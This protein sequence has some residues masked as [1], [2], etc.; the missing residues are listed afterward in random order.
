MKSSTA[1]KHNPWDIDGHPFMWQHCWCNCTGYQSVSRYGSR[2]WLFEALHPV[3]SFR[4]ALLQVVHLLLRSAAH[5]NPQKGIIIG[6]PYPVE[7][8]APWNVAGSFTFS[9]WTPGAT[10]DGEGQRAR[11]GEALG[12]WGSSSGACWILS[13]LFRG[14][15]PHS[16][17]K[18]RDW[19]KETLW[20]G[21]VYTGAR[22]NSSFPPS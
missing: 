8:P 13:P 3:I 16:S 6:S 20:W 4:D 12:V 1:A 21:E 9:L 5:S 14:S 15:P 22:G 18:S 19:S 2:C 10:L 17:W 7:L 11:D